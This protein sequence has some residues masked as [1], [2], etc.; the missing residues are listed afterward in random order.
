MSNTPSQNTAPAQPMIFEIRIKGHLGSQ[1]AA[2][3]EDMTIQRE[4]NGDTVLT[5][6]VIDQAALYGLL[7]KIRDLGMPLVSVIERTKVREDLTMKAIVYTQ[8][9]SPDVLKYQEVE[10]P[11]LRDNDVL[12][13]V[14]AASANPLDWH[15]MRGTPFLVRL[16]MGFRK[17][18]RN[19][20]GVDVAGQVAAVGKDVKAFQPGDAVFGHS[21]FGSFA[22]YVGASEERLVPKPDNITYEEAAAV[23]VAACTA[24]QGL[25]DT[26]QVQPGQKVLINGAAGGVGT[27]AVQIA[28]SFGAEVTGVC[29]TKNLELV[30]S[31]GADHVIDYT[32]EDFT[33]NGQRYDLILD[34]VGNRSIFDLRRA[35]TPAGK[36]VVVGFTSM[37]GLFQ[38]MVIGPLVSK[39]GS[40][41]IILMGTADVLQ[42]DLLFL[43][44]LLETGKIVS[45]IDR[46][47][48]LSQAA[49]AI[50]Y[51]ETGHARAKVIITV[52]ADS[53]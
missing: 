9:G 41:K 8:Y 27:Y 34:N 14:H 53:K 16:S 5:G 4:D 38:A 10:K 12:L 15:L 32:Q 36:A 43:K 49:D 1:W 50:R 24:L 39:M 31:I 33:K 28:K 7:K 2:W 17:P 6:P 18:K 45:V 42:K 29:S 19:R 3:F 40:R 23:A 46:C 35:L 22:E 25:R 21:Y 44:D 52:A 26:G 48:P 11:T 47:Y 37:A 30:R 51:L 20:I 13:K